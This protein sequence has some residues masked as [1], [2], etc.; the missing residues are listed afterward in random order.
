M[1]HY[2]P[3]VHDESIGLA[4]LKQLQLLQK[5]EPMTRTEAKNAWLKIFPP[6]GLFSNV[7]YLLADMT[8][9]SANFWTLIRAKYILIVAVKITNNLG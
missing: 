5:V 2:S 7:W 4:K 9:H 6:F 3:R 1:L 8:A